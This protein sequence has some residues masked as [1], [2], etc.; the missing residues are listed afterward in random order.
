MKILLIQPPIEDFYDTSI[1]TY[2]LGLLCIAAKT[3]EIADVSVLDARTGKRRVLGRHPFPDLSP[4]YA[5][6][7]STPF[8]FFSRYSRYGMTDEELAH[9]IS[10]ENPDLVGVS[11]LCSAYERQALQ[12]ARMAKAVNP[13]IVTVI[14]GIHPTL[15]PAEV[16]ANVDVDYCVRGEGETP[17]FQLIS[18]LSNDRR[19]RIDG[20]RGLCF[21][22]DD[23]LHLTQI[24]IEADIDTI[25]AR[26]CIDPDQYRIGGKRYSFLLTSRGCPFNCGFCGKPPVPYR[27]RS[28][29]SV[30]KEVAECER[31][32]IEA[33]DFE[34]DMLNLDRH[35]FSG[36][37]SLFTGHAFTLSAMNGI[38]PGGV[39]V[40]LLKAMY[41]AGFRRLNFSLVDTAEAVLIG[42][43]RQQHRS[44]IILLPF[45]EDSPFLVEAH[46]IIGLPFQ[47]PGGLLDTLLFLM[48]KRLLLGP[49]IFYLAPGS[50]VCPSGDAAG[51]AP[52]EQMRSS[53]MFP[54]N[55]LFPRTVIFTFIKLVRFI[56][57]VK[58]I[59]DR[60]EGIERIS[61][62]QDGPVTPGGEAD[63]LI[64]KQLLREKRLLWRQ[65]KS[66]SLV[67]EPV[68]QTLIAEFFK[69][70]KGRKIK[71]FKSSRSVA[72]DV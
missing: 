41:Q 69:K 67:D 55:P 45:L 26:H 56:N 7:V 11:S 20:I 46:F 49:S 44:F 51:Q 36:I 58:Q 12:V 57:W 1:R 50:T 43:K 59:I 52:F 38:Y 3:G 39:D 60:N 40:P 54:I 48:E 2:P 5:G 32:G 62:L 21:R 71:G 23:N 47:E 27:R 72:L 65:R 8:S 70:G 13:A 19:D 18:A 4:F 66:G 24:N 15:F 14:G 28:L 6:G 42:Q 10:R 22:K 34:D 37:L 35:F 31:L 17:F 9:A 16:L 53:F 29:A 64:V 68:D 61:E 33:I 30:E 25:P 63:R